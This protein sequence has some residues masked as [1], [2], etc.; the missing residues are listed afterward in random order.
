VGDDSRPVEL[1]DASQK[2]AAA[3]AAIADDEIVV[4]IVTCS[5]DQSFVCGLAQDSQGLLQADG[6]N[7]LVIV[8]GTLI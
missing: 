3:G 5:M 7:Q 6:S 4:S 8:V 1:D 2:A